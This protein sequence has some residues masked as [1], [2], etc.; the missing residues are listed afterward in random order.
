MIRNSIIA[1]LVVCTSVTL[2]AQNET[3]ALRY[4][5]HNPFGTSR[6]AAQGG[7]IGALGGDLSAAQSNPAGFGS[8]QKFRVF[9]HALFL[10]GKYKIRLYGL[11]CRGFP[12]PV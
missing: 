2:Q 5:M 12:L 11:Q 1:L 7:A 8:L 3:Q 4:S 6:Y 9:N 10:L